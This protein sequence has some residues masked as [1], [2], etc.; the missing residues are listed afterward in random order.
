[1][2]LLLSK[3]VDEVPAHK[4]TV[5][6]SLNTTGKHE[7]TFRAHSGSYTGEHMF[8]ESARDNTTGHAKRNWIDGNGNHGHILSATSASLTGY[9]SGIGYWND[10]SG[11]QGS[12]IVSTQTSGGKISMLSKDGSCNY[13][14][15]FNVSHTH[16]LSLSNSGADKAHNNY[17]PYIAIYIW[18]RVS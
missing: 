8:Y 4:H 6:V 2:Y 1:M 9:L 17:P 3:S 14:V 11:G 15:A 13:R 10:G 16:T 18:K 7:H 5:A 12:G